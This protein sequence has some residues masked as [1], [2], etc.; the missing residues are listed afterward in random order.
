MRRPGS[1]H[2]AASALAAALVMLTVLAPC[3]APHDPLAS[4]TARRLEAPGVDY[5]LGTDHLGRCVLSRVLHGTRISLWL[6]LSVVLGSALLGAL[7]GSVS[8]YIGGGIDLA[9]TGLTDLFLAFPR[10]VLALVAV[11]LIGPS[12]GVV[13]LVLVVLDWTAYARLTRSV[14]LAE[15]EQ[16]WFL[17]DR[18]LGFSG[19]R[20]L[21]GTLLPASIPPLTAYGVLRSGSTLL[22]IAGLGFLGIGAP[23]PTPEW[24]AMIG[25]G[26][27]FLRAAPWIC[28]APG[29]AMVGVILGFSLL[30]ESLHRTTHTH[31]DLR[32]RA[33][34]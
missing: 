21:F 1:V 27:V 31:R 22:T 20:L 8:G 7:V 18:A 3:F 2:V 9:V 15:K 30:G 33:V 4:H 28:I 34:R 6:T 24:G 13:V 25:Q 17:A 12:L 29:L 16:A 23:P 10:L 14:V 32:K 5:P 11:G 19:P 26:R